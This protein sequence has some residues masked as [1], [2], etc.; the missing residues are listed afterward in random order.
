MWHQAGARVVLGDEGGGEPH[1]V[2]IRL[3]R[4]QKGRTRRTATLDGK[5]VA[6]TA[7][8]GRV[9]MVLF[10]PEE[11]TLIRGPGE[12][13]RR[14]L[15]GVLAQARKGYAALLS[16]Y[17]RVLEQRNQLLKRIVQELDTEA[18]LAVWTDELARLGAEIVVAR[19]ECL[20]ELAPLAAAK[21]T[22]VAGGEQLVVRYAPSVDHPGD[23]AGEIIAALNA[24]R[25][26]ELA[27]GTTVAGPHRDDLEIELGGMPAAA[28]ASQGQ[29]RTAI[30]ALKLA[31][32]DL[33]ARG[34]EAPVLLLDDVMSELDGARREHLLSLV[35]ASPQ[36]VITSAE[37][38][39]FPAGFI[40]TV[41]TRRVRGGHVE[42]DADA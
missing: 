3:E 27:R 4:G 29:Q 30:L 19:R 25:R 16:R 14:L 35:Q 1:A 31:E 40:D 6:P 41:V 39:Y 36:A 11:M 17:G 5:R 33:L 42:R 28:H 8:A 23:V 34:G 9:K 20:A 13:R 15:N 38:G 18:S 7:L 37:A 2:E 32:V 24:R 12:P 22:E 26:E 21:Y 10:H